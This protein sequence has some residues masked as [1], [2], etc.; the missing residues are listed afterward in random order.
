MYIKPVSK[1]QYDNQGVLVENNNNYK[2]ID[3]NNLPKDSNKLDKKHFATL[4]R[5]L[6]NSWGLSSENPINFDGNNLTIKTNSLIPL[7]WKEPYEDQQVK[8]YSIELNKRFVTRDEYN[9]NNLNI[10][11]LP[12]IDSYESLKEELNNKSQEELKSYD[13]IR[14]KH[15]LWTGVWFSQDNTKDFISMQAFMDKDKNLQIRY[16]SIFHN[17]SPIIV[18]EEIHL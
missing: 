5:M 10:L 3:S 2:L 15:D 6:N 17:S 18:N 16:L 9:S 7:K 4:L 1:E 12:N 13:Y 8:T 14:T 11:N